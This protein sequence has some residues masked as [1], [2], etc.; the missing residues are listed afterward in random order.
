MSSK[1]EES[2]T[3]HIKGPWRFLN[4]KPGLTQGHHLSASEDEGS[5]SSLDHWASVIVELSYA[6]LKAISLPLS[7][8]GG[9]SDFGTSLKTVERR[10]LNSLR[11]RGSSAQNPESH[12][13]NSWHRGPPFSALYPPS[14]P[15]LCSS[16]FPLLTLLQMHL[17]TSTHLREPIF[18]DIW[19]QCSYTFTVFGHKCQ[20]NKEGFADHPIL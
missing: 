9:G 20:D 6:E 16:L 2:E 8:D 15:S 14:S 19:A 7:L 3:V 17:A 11:S 18:L 4:S 10:T 1:R 12:Q 13:R 5:L